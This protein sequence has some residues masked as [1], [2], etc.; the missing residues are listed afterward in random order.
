MSDLDDLLP[1]GPQEE[2][3]NETPVEAEAET[4]EGEAVEAEVEPQEEPK[5]DPKTVPL[6]A[7]IEQRKEFQ[8][9][10]DAVQQKLDEIAKPKPEPVKAPEFLDPEG[11]QYFQGMVSN[12]Q[13][14]FAAELSETKAR[15]KYGEE[16]VDEAIKAATQ[17][18][19]VDSF[20][21]QPDAWGKLAEWHK[22]QKVVAE[23]GDDPQAF[24]AKMREELLAEIKSELAAEQVKAAAGQPAPSLAGVQGTG[25]AAQGKW[26]G[27]RAIDDLLS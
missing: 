11:A 14:N 24:K 8:A 6:A 15:M 19:M 22:Q 26:N 2:V 20:K 21:G 13:A 4:P 3:Q 7:H 16:H 25:N 12:M 5:E 9:K 17:A 1:E 18:N 23:I 10:L 27:P